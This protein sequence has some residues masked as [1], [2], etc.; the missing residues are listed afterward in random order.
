MLQWLNYYNTCIVTILLYLNYCV[1]I[2][3][4][5]RAD[6]ELDIFL[7]IQIWA[8]QEKKTK[9]NKKKAQNKLV[10]VWAQFK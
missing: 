1:A 5:Y 3:Y 9:Q 7:V 8:W 4:S 10:R 6:L 2:I